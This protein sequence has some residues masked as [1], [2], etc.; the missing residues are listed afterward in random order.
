[1]YSGR[2]GWLTR[3]SLDQSEDAF[4]VNVFSPAGD[5]SGLPVLVR[6]Q[7]FPFKPQ[8]HA[9]DPILYK[10]LVLVS[11]HQV[12]CLGDM[13]LKTSLFTA[14]GTCT[15]GRLTILFMTHPNSYANKNWREILAL[16]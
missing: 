2:R 12:S 3:E 11:S 16:S 4:T 7:G 5:F 13:R 10:G 1:M 6:L 8:F 9:A 15:P 14:E